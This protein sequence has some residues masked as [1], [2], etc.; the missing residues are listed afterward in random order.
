MFTLFCLKQAM[1]KPHPATIRSKS[2][3]K[4]VSVGSSQ[5]TT[6]M[7]TTTTTTMAE[8]KTLNVDLQQSHPA[9]NSRSVSESQIEVDKTYPTD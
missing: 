2:Q 5:R 4:S 1:K 3:Q 7:T 6:T 8:P 9:T